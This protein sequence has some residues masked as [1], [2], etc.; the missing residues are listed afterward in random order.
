MARIGVIP[1]REVDGK[2]KS[3]PLRIKLGIVKSVQ[4]LVAEENK[5]TGQKVA[6]GILVRAR[7]TN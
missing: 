6:L 1:V 4:I 2:I 7:S 5:R 3:R